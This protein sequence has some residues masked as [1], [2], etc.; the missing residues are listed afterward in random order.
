[1]KTSIGLI[2]AVFFGVLLLSA[3]AFADETQTTLMLGGQNCRYHVADV[4][5]AL[6][7]VK[8]VTNVDTESLKGHAIIKHDDSVTTETLIA[9]VKTVKGKKDDAEFA[10]DA[11]TM[12]MD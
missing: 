1:M 5:K 6:K 9:V 11:M 10:C 7:A 8:G 4:A 2:G 12:T 3:P